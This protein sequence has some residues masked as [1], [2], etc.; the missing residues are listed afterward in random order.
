MDNYALR[1]FFKSHDSALIN[2]ESIFL[3]R[4]DVDFYSNIYLNKFNNGG[5]ST[6]QLKA[7]DGYLYSRVSFFTKD[8][9]GVTAHVIFTSRTEN[10]NDAVFITRIKSN[11]EGLT[12]ADAAPLNFI[13]GM[14][15]IKASGTLVNGVIIVSFV[16]GNT[17]GAYVVALDAETYEQLSPVELIDEAL[18]LRYFD[19]MLGQMTGAIAQFSDDNHG[20]FLQLSNVRENISVFKLEFDKNL[21][22]SCTKLFVITEDDI[23]AFAGLY[24]KDKSL[25]I[26]CYCQF[27]PLSKNWSVN[28]VANKVFGKVDEQRY[29]AY[30]AL[31]LNSSPGIYYR[32]QVDKAEN[33]YVVSWEGAD[34]L[35][36]KKFNEQINAVSPEVYFSANKPGNHQ[37]VYIDGEYFVGYQ[38]DCSEPRFVGLGYK[39]DR[40]KSDND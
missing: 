15:I 14:S 7:P 20:C 24:D 28:G 17:N 19:E 23:G 34:M 5:W 27:D 6:T 33:G 8:Y 3:Y 35:H 29:D 25:V 12:L 32:P 9:D 31:P 16:D 4:K 1:T 18:S 11:D 39:N 10:D 22:L 26:T 38:T 13:N 30:S 40:V 2:G 21:G 37:M 36:F